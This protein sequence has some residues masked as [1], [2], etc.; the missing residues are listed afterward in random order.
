MGNRR[1]PLLATLFLGALAVVAVLV[2][3]KKPSKNGVEFI[4]RVQ[5]A[6]EAQANERKEI[7]DTVEI[8]RERTRSLGFYG[9]NV[10]RLGA[11]DIKVSLP[12]VR[13][14]RRAAE[15]LGSTGQLYLYDWET[16]LLGPEREIGANPGQEPPRGSLS[17]SEERWMEAGRD[18]RDLESQQL[19]FSGA[20]PT[21]Y[22]A[23]LLAAEQEPRASDGCSSS[24][25][26]FYLFE[27]GEPHELIS[28]PE[29]SRASLYGSP[30]QQKRP[31][32][33][34]VV[35]VPAGFILVSGQPSDEHG[36]TDFNAEPGWYAIRDNPALSGTDITDS[37]PGSN[38]LGQPSITFNFTDE[39]REAFQ[40]LTREIAQ[41]GQARAIG[42]VGAE[43]ANALSGHFAVVLDNE[44]KVRPILN[45][46]ENPD[47]I[48]GR[49]GAAISGGFRGPD[50]AR[51]LATML[52]IGALPVP[53]Q[54]VRQ[55]Q[56]TNMLDCPP[57]RA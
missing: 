7:E 43:Q 55:R 57:D 28:G 15:T 34:I 29:L 23:A 32:G 1:W 38:Q 5:P 49:S 40:A 52:R 12:D 24:R 14:A 41:Q 13:S 17:A 51:E 53:L 35:E 20:F 42:P 9:S 22:G 26:L 18:V 2:F 3:A 37:K 50:E 48:D 31:R 21:L 4:Y 25:P 6:C 30:N 10:A 47:G 45:F 36:E 27:R 44:V 39:G 33:G 16:S 56:G 11:T 19:I 46:A 54:L 8:I